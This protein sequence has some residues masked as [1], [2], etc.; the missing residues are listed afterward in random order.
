MMVDISEIKDMVGAF[1]D[2]SV[3]ESMDPLELGSEELVFHGPINAE[4]RIQNDK[5][6][7]FVE[8]TIQAKVLLKC[9]RCLES[10]IHPISGTVYA[11]YLQAPTEKSVSEGDFEGD[12]T[13]LQE[14]FKIDLTPALRESILLALPAKVLCSQDCKGLCSICGKDLNDGECDCQAQEIDS[15]FA[16][17]KQLLED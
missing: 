3:Q 7:I 9:S 4:L 15:R 8:G 10:L 12:E 14:G 6:S 5:S 1:M 17:L 2:V 13:F 16:V 11:R